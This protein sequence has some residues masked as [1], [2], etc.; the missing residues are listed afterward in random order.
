MTISPLFKN[1]LIV[2][3]AFLRGLNSGVLFL[4]I[5]VG[6]QTINIFGVLRIF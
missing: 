3:V 5:G 6:T 2:F 4:L 1:L